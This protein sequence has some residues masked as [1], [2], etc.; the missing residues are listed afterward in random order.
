[1]FISRVPDHVDF[2]VPGVDVENGTDAD[3]VVAM[4]TEV[5]DELVFDGDAWEELEVFRRLLEHFA[6]WVEAVH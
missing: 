4:V 2:V 3:H 6:G 1:M 5:L